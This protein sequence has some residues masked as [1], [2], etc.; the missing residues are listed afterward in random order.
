[1]KPIQESRTFWLNLGAGAL[2]VFLTSLLAAP[3][4]TLPVWV[5]VLCAALL[6]VCNFLTVALRVQDQSRRQSPP[7]PNVSHAPADDSL[8]ASGRRFGGPR[9]AK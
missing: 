8:S 2:A 7:L 5:A 6:A 3:V 4:G 1:M 9:R